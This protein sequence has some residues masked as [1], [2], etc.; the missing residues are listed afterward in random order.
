MLPTT[1][2]M[3]DKAHQVSERAG[4]VMHWIANHTGIPAL[5]VAALA[6]V[7]SWKLFKAGL[8]LAVEV[9]IVALALF[10]AAQVGWIKF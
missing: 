6:I 7:L 2:E 9:A 1:N 8:H 3:A 10:V 4:G 5:L